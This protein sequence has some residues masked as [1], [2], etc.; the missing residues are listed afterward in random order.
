M[1][2]AQAVLKEKLNLRTE[3]VLVQPIPYARKTAEI[4]KQT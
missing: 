4:L 2:H 3:N 1:Q